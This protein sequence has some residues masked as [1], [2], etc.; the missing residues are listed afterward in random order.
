VGPCDWIVKVMPSAGETDPSCASAR[1]RDS[2][3][4]VVSMVV[5]AH[6]LPRCS[7]VLAASLSA[8]PD[9]AALPF[10]DRPATLEKSG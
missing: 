1:K 8:A 2:N 7:G 3:D 5:C 10:S 6:T 4:V 9:W